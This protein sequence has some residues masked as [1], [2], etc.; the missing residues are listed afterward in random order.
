LQGRQVEALRWL[1]TAV[2]LGNWNYRWFETD[3]NW[4][5]FRDDPRFVDLMSRIKSRGNKSENNKGEANKSES[6]TA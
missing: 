2:D 4:A 1:E 3:P 6:Q 5:S